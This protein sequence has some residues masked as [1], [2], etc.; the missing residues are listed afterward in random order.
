MKT[1]LLLKS[2]LSPE[3]LLSLNSWGSDR[4]VSEHS[5]IISRI[6]KNFF[7]VFYVLCSFPIAIKFVKTHVR[8][9][10]IKG[11][12]RMGRWNE[13]QI[14][15][16]PFYCSFVARLYNKMPFPLNIDNK[17]SR[18]RFLQQSFVKRA[19]VTKAVEGNAS[20]VFSSFFIITILIS[21]HRPQHL[22]SI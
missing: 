15:I 18:W 12:Q 2:L 7:I 1:D 8:M 21:A 3:F 20:E 16:L 22:I 9:S 4:S 17:V 19:D 13:T 11:T 6:I 10:N 14:D 5:K